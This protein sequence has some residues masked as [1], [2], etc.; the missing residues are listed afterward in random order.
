[1]KTVRYI[2][3]SLIAVLTMNACDL[4]EFQAPLSDV[5]VTLDMKTDCADLVT[6]ATE[7]GDDEYNENLIESI[8]WYFF[9]NDDEWILDG[10]QTINKTA[11]A[12][13][14]LSGI[15]ADDFLTIFPSGGHTSVKVL[16]V[17]NASTPAGSTGVTMD[18]IKATVLTM[19]G[20]GVQDSFAMCGEGTLTK[21]T[22][23]TVLS[24]STTSTIELKRIASKFR[25]KLSI[26][27][28]YIS[29]EDG[30]IWRPEVDDLLMSFKNLEPKTDV[31]G[32]PAKSTGTGLKTLSFS[33]AD[34]DLEEVSAGDDSHPCVWKLV[35][36]VYSYPREWEIDDTDY[37][38]FYITLP[39]TKSTTGGS[40]TKTS[41]Y[42]VMFPTESFVSNN[43]YDITINLDGLGSLVP[44]ATVTIDDMSLIVTGEW[45]DAI[46]E[47]NKNNTDA[48]IAAPHVLAIDSNI[49]TIYNENSISIPF[50]SSHNCEIVDASTSEINAA[51]LPKNQDSGAGTAVSVLGV[52]NDTQVINFT[53]TLTNMPS[54]GSTYD[55]KAFIHTYKLRH[56]SD[57]TTYEYVTIIQK[58]SICIEEETSNGGNG[59]IFI[60]G[61]ELTSS[62]NGDHSY[63]ILKTSSGVTATGIQRVSTGVLP[64]SGTLADFK[65]GD[66]RDRKN[67]ITN[68]TNTLKNASIHYGNNETA[69]AIYRGTGYSG[70]PTANSTF[71]FAEVSGSP[72]VHING[73][74]KNNVTI[75]YPT[76]SDAEAKNIIAPEFLIASGYPGINSH[77]LNNE[78]AILRCAAYQ[79][80]G[81][82]AGRWRLPTK[83]EITYMARLQFDGH[84]LKIFNNSSPYVAADG[85]YNIN[86][87]SLN[88][89]FSRTYQATY[90]SV[91]CV[92]DSW[93]WDQV[94]KEN[95]WD[96]T[97][98]S[99]LTTFTY[100][101]MPIE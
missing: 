26:N 67:P 69:D 38:Y 29:A 86:N 31:S 71:D 48:D 25:V 62:G 14:S 65:I 96:A 83:A 8:H 88:Q 79:E 3:L 9:D 75:Y 39:W 32:K 68:F 51:G 24:A 40:E 87:S 5:S 43:L 41:Y 52:D 63:R 37:P 33:V 72:G 64:T 60:H 45:K 61:A 82:P 55:Y 12:N 66:P 57:G 90:A 58:P 16:V 17:V 73:T 30:S 34:E 89:S 101:D 99:R 22:G 13:I 23:T 94:D 93:Y 95:G 56:I 47:V 7:A 19:T 36:P 70:T 44:E 59:Y 54:T 46:E 27:N 4:K 10:S 78:A 76:R 91:R 2:I 85:N 1:M 84:I 18:D 49:Y 98:S 92:Y 20:L 74:T 15:D 21:G 100:G 6:K 11:E 81:Y 53:H 77:F 42:R 28:K 35:D 97:R 50:I 80:I